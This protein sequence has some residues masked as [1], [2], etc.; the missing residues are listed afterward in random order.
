MTFTYLNSANRSQRNAGTVRRVMS[1]FLTSALLIVGALAMS[2]SAWAAPQGNMQSLLPNMADQPRPVALHIEPVDFALGPGFCIFG[3]HHGKGSGC[4]G[5]SINDGNQCLIGRIPS[6]NGLSA[7]PCAGPNF[8]W[9][10]VGNASK[11]A[12][13]VGAG[14]YGLEGSWS[15]RETMKKG[16]H[17][18]E[19]W[20]P[21]VGEAAAGLGAYQAYKDCQ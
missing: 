14:A 18:A 9:D 15:A 19:R 16:G 7:G 11:C 2:G 5:G 21:G 10:A 6:A 1:A 17:F 4:R 3:T 13:S 20:V 12:A 8:N